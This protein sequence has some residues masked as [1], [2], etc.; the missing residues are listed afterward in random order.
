MPARRHGGHGRSG[1]RH[2]VRGLRDGRLRR[3]ARAAPSVNAVVARES[4]RS[5]AEH[6]W[7]M[8][9]DSDEPGRS[10]QR[11]RQ[12]IPGRVD[13]TFRIVGAT[14]PEPSARRQ[15]GIRRR[16]HP[17]DYQPLY[18]TFEPL[19]NPPCPLGHWKHPLQR[20]DRP[21]PTREQRGRHTGLC[22]RAAHRPA[23][24]IVVH[25]FQYRVPSDP[26]PAGH[27][28]ELVE[29]SGPRRVARIRRLAQ[30]RPPAGVPRGCAYPTVGTP[31]GH[32][33]LTPA[34]RAEA[35]YPLSM[36]RYLASTRRWYSR[37]ARGLGPTQRRRRATPELA[38]IPWPQS[39]ID[40]DRRHVSSH[41]KGQSSSAALEG[42][43]PVWS[44][45]SCVACGSTPA[46][47]E[48]GRR[49]QVV[50]PALQSAPM[51]P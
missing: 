42:A 32:A 30:L 7:W 43:A 26:S 15:A 31:S 44:S 29:S 48:Q 16:I 41:T 2:H 39:S 9:L 25:H 47:S 34:S 24:G 8:L 19:N 11:D 46:R 38:G 1:R 4:L 36:E 50:L 17:F 37:Y 49:Q 27:K 13:R 14:F 51:G 40:P 10:Q 22:L 21:R 28:L 20:F 6:V 3:T 18:Y 33:L 23:A 12:G 5:E 35:G 45:R